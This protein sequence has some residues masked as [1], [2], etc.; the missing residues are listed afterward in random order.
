MQPFE[1]LVSE[2]AAAHDLGRGEAAAV[3]R[4][5]RP[6]LHRV[7]LVEIARSRPGGADQ[8]EA[9]ATSTPSEAKGRW[10]RAPALRA[11]FRNDFQRFEAFSR[12]QG[13]QR[14][15]VSRPVVIRQ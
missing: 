2:I 10:E 14:L 13:S 12:A 6:D 15:R 8:P 11:E 7:H 1:Q 3:A 9:I 5:L 4:E